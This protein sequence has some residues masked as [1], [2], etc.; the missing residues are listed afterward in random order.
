MKPN[1]LG[2]KGV[3]GK[4]REHDAGD[5]HIVE[6]RDQKHAVVKREIRRRHRHRTPVNKRPIYRR[7]G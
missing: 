3:A 7:S 4:R 2:T 1:A 6:M 5:D